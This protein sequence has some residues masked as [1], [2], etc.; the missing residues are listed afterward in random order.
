MS[1]WYRKASLA[2]VIAGCLPVGACFSLDD[3]D[4]DVEH[5]TYV[6]DWRDE[7]IYQVLVDRFANGD[8]SNDWGVVPHAPA[9]YHGGDWKGLEDKLDYIQGLGMTTLWISPIVKNV[10]SDATIDGY[11]GY[12]TQDFTGLNPHFGDM[13]SL[14]SLVNAAHKRN[15]KVILDIVTNHVGQ[16]FFYDINGNGVPD[17]AVWGGGYQ[18]PGDPAHPVEHRTEYDPDYEEPYVQ[19]RTSLGEA[20][21]SPIFFFQDGNSNH[22][23]PRC[24]GCPDPGLFLRR[25]AYHLRGRV[26][27]WGDD[28]C[29]FYKAEG[30]PFP[31]NTCP[32]PGVPESKFSDTACNQVP[33]GDF[34]GGLKDLATENPKVRQAMQYVFRRW[35][36]LVDFD[37]FRIDTVK[38]VDHGFWKEFATGIRQYAKTELKKD[39]FLMFGE[40][41][42]GV[43]PLIG[44]YT[45]E[46]ELDSAFYFSQKYMVFDEVFKTEGPTHKVHELF[47]QRDANYG[48]GDTQQAQVDGAGLP[49]E[50]ILV[51]FIDNHDVARFLFHKPSKPALLTALAFLFTE[52]GIPCLYYGTEQDFAGGNDPANREDLWATGFNTKGDTFRFIQKLT[53]L[54]KQHVALRRG[55]LELTMTDRQGAGILALER[56]TDTDRVL[57]VINTS[58]DQFKDTFGFHPKDDLSA[59]PA[60]VAR[61]LR[62][63]FAQ[64]TA[65]RDVLGMVADGGTTVGPNGE[66]N[67]N[68]GPREVRI[69]VP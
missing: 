36:K 7:M 68:L 60:P 21:P 40:S 5:K 22:M 23:A 61:A 38:H 30:V 46:G 59:D 53:G 14:R 19:S 34:P 8:T 42:T 39:R 51:N 15:M 65:L 2:L 9:R 33:Y 54:R 49:A 24:D 37:G 41:F 69:L 4:K 10:D 20:G 27:E 3:L 58:D 31:P 43:D 56:F 12:W 16:V 26:W 64:G 1:S 67:I 32:R 6:E 63:G 50:K 13:A 25:E 52:D 48:W 55:D 18:M 62:T 29:C 35:L 45:R 44:A 28:V 57:V 47:S 66:V 17:E 11:H